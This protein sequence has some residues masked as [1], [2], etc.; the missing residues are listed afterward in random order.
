MR[1]FEAVQALGKFG[2]A[3]R[4]AIPGLRDCLQDSDTS[5]R[6]AAKMAP[7]FVEQSPEGGDE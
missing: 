3:A 6:D 1:S 5:V 7:R 4:D 2:P